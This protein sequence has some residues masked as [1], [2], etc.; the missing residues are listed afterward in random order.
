MG[1]MARMLLLVAAAAGLMLVP[2]TDGTAPGAPERCVNSFIYEGSVYGYIPIDGENLVSGRHVGRGV[3]RGCTDIGGVPPPPDKRVKLYRFGT[4]NPRVA[5][6]IRE[7]G[8]FVVAVSSR[9]FGF[10]LR[11][12]PHC[13]Q[14]EVRFKGRGYSPVRGLG[15]TQGGALGQGQ[16]RDR[17]V[18]LLAIQRIDPRIALVRDDEPESTYIAHRRCELVPI[19]PGFKRC[20]GAP[21]WLA[22]RGHTRVRTATIESPGSLV[23]SARLRLFLAPDGVAD[24]ITSPEDER[25]TLVGRLIVDG[26]GRGSTRLTIDDSLAYGRYAVLAQVPGSR[27]VVVG[28][29]HVRR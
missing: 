15:L 1:E 16:V 10:D 17:R 18:R 29:L 6:T 9:C 26:K 20:L 14:T 25:L 5:L 4:A 28:A 2:G 19:Y 12:Y 24:Q 3:R 8:P 11:D 23:T 27:V 21:L 13:L 7:Q 22:I